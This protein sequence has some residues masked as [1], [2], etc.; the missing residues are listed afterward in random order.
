MNS[1]HLFAGIGGGILADK[2]LGHR[3]VGAVEIEPYCRAVLKQRQEEGLLEPFPLFDDIRKLPTPRVWDATRE[4][5]AESA[6]S[7]MK[8]DSPPLAIQVSVTSPAGGKLNPRW[9]EW[10]MGFPIEWTDLKD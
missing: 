4:I 8:V 3:I 5:G 6:D 2:I 9:V 7:Y 10:L 1:L